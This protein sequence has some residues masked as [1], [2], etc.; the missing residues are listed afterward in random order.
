[1]VVGV[2]KPVILVP[3]AVLTGL[4]ATQVELLLAH[5]LAHIA[6]H[7]VLANALQRAVETL[8]FFHPAVWWLSARLR[9]ERERCCDAMAADL[10]GDPCGMAEALTSL[11]ALHHLPLVPAFALGASG[12]SL[13]ERV[14]ALLGFTAPVRR[15]RLLLAGG[16]VLVCVG[17]GLGLWRLRAHRLAR[18]AT[19]RQARLQGFP[20]GLWLRGSGSE[21]Q[22]EF[23]VHQASADDVLAAF[24]RAEARL[25]REGGTVIM[26]G[27]PAQAASGKNQPETFTV[28]RHSLSR[29]Q[30]LE[31][32]S[33][34]KARPALDCPATAL[35]VRRDNLALP[36][37][38]QE[39][40]PLDIW[41][42]KHAEQFNPEAA[43]LLREAVQELKALAV[44]P[45]RPQEVRKAV[46]EAIL[47]TL[48]SPDPGMPTL[49]AWD[50]GRE[51]ALFKLCQEAPFEPMAGLRYELNHLQVALGN[52]SAEDGK[53][54][55]AAKEALTRH[56]VSITWNRTHRSRTAREQQ[57]RKA[58]EDQTHQFQA[59]LQELENGLVR[60][61]IQGAALLLRQRLA[62]L[63]G[64]PIP[65]PTGKSRLRV[66]VGLPPSYSAN[67]FMVPG[68]RPIG[69]PTLT[70]GS[71]TTDADTLRA[72][73]AQEIA[74]LQ[75][76][77][78]T[79]QACLRGEHGYESRTLW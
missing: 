75:S 40:P 17:T 41:V 9:Q 32:W 11:E 58:W 65:A 35:V 27:V 31:Y 64:K 44:T 4:P 61:S 29:S 46:P 7:D 76:V 62:K 57:A 51:E 36:W 67:V 69:H 23:E 43:R 70:V 8:L 6:R 19:Q 56:R 14:Q 13:T 45:G 39:D 10:L 1:M 50:T 5:E 2:I 47:A 59:A 74:L 16:L 37:D 15:L 71:L 68:R 24:A 12:G 72:S 77:E 52:P 25:A 22:I 78:A 20:G 48:R 33:R 53:A 66:Q 30:F 79:L 60:K 18:L 55:Q 28:P 42:P 63:G 54:L 38:P 34:L 21:A 3:A 73:P 26:E 49:R